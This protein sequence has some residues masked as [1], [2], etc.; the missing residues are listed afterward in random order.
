M[1]WIL[2]RGRGIVGMSAP[3]LDYFMVVLVALRGLSQ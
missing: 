2:V 3:S 1:T